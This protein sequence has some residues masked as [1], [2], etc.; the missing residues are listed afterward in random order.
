MVNVLSRGLGCVSSVGSGSFRRVGSVG[1]WDFQRVG[2]VESLG[3]S[4]S[5]SVNNRRASL[6]TPECDREPGVD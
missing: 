2:G 3:C 5:A 1:S 6:R 4:K